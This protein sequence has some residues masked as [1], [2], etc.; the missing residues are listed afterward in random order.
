MKMKNKFAVVTG[1]STG[2]GRA[3]ALELA[4]EGAFIAL[5]G[6]TQDKLL[7]TKSLIAENGGQAGVFLGDFTKPDSL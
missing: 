2:I 1:S 4:K 6:R 5:A 7:R 3:I